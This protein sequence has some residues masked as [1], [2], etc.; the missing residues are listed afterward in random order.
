MLVRKIEEIPTQGNAATLGACE[1]LLA[2][3]SG[4]F[5]SFQISFSSLAFNL[6][7]VLFT[8][9]YSSCLNFTERC[10]SEL[11]KESAR[12][13]DAEFSE[14]AHYLHPLKFPE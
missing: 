12:Q 8:H 13:M 3:R 14:A 2:I 9:S 7:V 4:L 1:R 5:T 10:K 11:L 6:F